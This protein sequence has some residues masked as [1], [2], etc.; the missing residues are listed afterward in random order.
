MT[1]PSLPQAPSSHTRPE[2]VGVTCAPSDRLAAALDCVRRGW[3]IFPL[4][5]NTR[6]PWKPNGQRFASRETHQVAEWWHENPD[7]NVGGSTNDKIVVEIVASGN[8]VDLRGRPRRRLGH[9]GR[10]REGITAFCSLAAVGGRLPATSVARLLIDAR[11]SP[12]DDCVMFSLPDRVGVAGAVDGLGAGLDLKSYDDFVV[13]PGSTIDA[14]ASAW[15]NDREIAGAPDWLV[16]ACSPVEPHERSETESPDNIETVNASPEPQASG[17]EMTDMANVTPETPD[18]ERSS[19][20][21]AIEWVNID[22]PEGAGEGRALAARDVA[23]KLFRWP[24]LTI[25]AATELMETWSVCYCS[26]SLTP[27]EMQAVLAE[28]KTT[29]PAATAPAKTDEPNTALA[30]KFLEIL[31]PAGRHDIVSIDPALPTKHPNK[32][33]GLTLDGPLS[34]GAAREWIDARQGRLNLYLSSNAGRLDAHRDYRLNKEEIG[35]L[36]AIVADVDPAKIKAGDNRG[37]NFRRERERLRELVRTLSADPTCPPTMVID[38]GGGF[39]FWWFL[40][41]H[42]PATDENRVLV[43]GIGRTIRDRIGGDNVQSIEH[44][45]RLPGTVNVPDE[46]KRLQGRVPAV[47]TVLEQGCGLPYTIDALAVWAPPTKATAYN[48]TDLSGVDLDMVAVQEAHEWV[49][50]PPKF[51]AACDRDP[52]LKA[53]WSGTPALEQ[54]GTSA[55][56]FEWALSGRLHRAGDYSLTEYAQLVAVWPYQS[57]KHAD[58]FERRVIRSWLRHPWAKS[59]T[60]SGFDATLIPPRYADQVDAPAAKAAEVSAPSTDVPDETNAALN[61]STPDILPTPQRRFAANVRAPRPWVIPEFA[62]RGNVGNLTGPSGVAKSTYAL[63]LAL[64]AVTGRD[65]ICGFPVPTRNRVWFWNQEDDREEIERRLEALM[66]AFDISWADLDDAEGNTRLFIDS[67]VDKALLL[68]SRKDRALR[69][70]G[71]VEKIVAGVKA[72]GIDLMI[73][74]PLVEFH[75]GEEN[76]NS[77]MRLVVGLVRQLAVQGECAV[78][79]ISHTRKPDKAKSDG[80]AGNMDSVRGAGSQGGVV[81]IVS[82]LFGM[83]PK[84]AKEWSIEGSHN[85]YVRLDMAKTNLG[86]MRTEPIWFRRDSIKVAGEDIGVLRPIALKRKG[87]VTAEVDLVRLL[88]KTLADNGQRGRYEAVKDVI[89]AMSDEDQAAFGPASNR[90]KKVKS[91]FNDAEETMTDYGKLALQKRNGAT[92]YCVR[93]NDEIATR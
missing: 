68:A 38:S 35:T 19:S 73:M 23:A 4:L 62:C 48:E 22:A 24:N 3:R 89:A 7:F 91:A 21:T 20:A 36:R 30:L 2:S 64:A 80:F 77:E 79:L 37:T 61:L 56:E 13:L 60:P 49:D 46:D 71:Q 86:K 93:L 66:T 17:E 69:S 12:I 92:G 53:L 54:K 9:D 1:A 27:A 31:D 76:N 70:T 51:V 42:L 34:A 10:R 74:D 28:A 5:P 58:Q 14:Y 29:N 6:T 59:D 88:A 63:A 40:S 84:D 87:N 75:E 16:A 72:R 45:F 11:I 82:T 18:A 81:R 85:D 43:A 50:L 52:V 25:D 8:G 15:K 55:S 83:S 65:D 44:I 41:P 47:A 78:Q 26:P 57:T 32:I 39:Q 67:G 33:N 90:S